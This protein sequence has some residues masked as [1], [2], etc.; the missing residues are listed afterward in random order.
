MAFFDSEEDPRV[1]SRVQE[2]PDKS[3]CYECGE[4]GHLSYECPKNLV[5]QSGPN[6]SSLKLLSS[7]KAHSFLNGLLT[8][9][10]SLGPNRV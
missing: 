5:R 7:F 1:H 3:R 8:C 6:L 4:E 9:G 2:Y 10:C